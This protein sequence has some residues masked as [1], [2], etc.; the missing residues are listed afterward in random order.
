MLRFLPALTFSES[1]SAILQK[2]SREPGVAPSSFA[3][4]KGGA[5]QHSFCLLT[6]WEPPCLL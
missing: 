3:M 1:T 4:Y 6:V 2:S 5:A